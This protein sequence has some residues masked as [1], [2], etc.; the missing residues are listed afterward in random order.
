VASEYKFQKIVLL[1]IVILLPFADANQ[2]NH[3]KQ[4]RTAQKITAT[5]ASGDILCRYGDGVFSRYFSAAASKAS[6]YSHVGIVACKGDSVYVYHVEASELTG[7]GVVK[8]EPLADFLSAITTYGLYRSSFS[9]DITAKMVTQAVV[10]YQRKIPFDLA[11]DASNDRKLYCTELVADCINH[12]T[13]DSTI[14]PGLQI[15]HRLFYSID[16]IYLNK[17]M[18]CIFKTA[19]S[20]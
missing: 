8:K 2:L 12:A 13:S 16:D 7:V 14:K 3:F 10:Y 20:D 6:V 4:L 15:R 17:H 5:Y 11:F 9:P 18:K 1:A 19:A